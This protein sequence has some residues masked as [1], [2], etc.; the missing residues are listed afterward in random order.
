MGGYEQ[1]S[2]GQER[3]SFHEQVLRKFV[4][5]VNS[6]GNKLVLP[7]AMPP[8]RNLSRRKRYRKKTVIVQNFMIPEWVEMTPPGTVLLQGQSMPPD[9][10]PPAT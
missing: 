6:L 7:N 3:K 8:E 5:S 4:D 2:E 9:R 1:T 10:S